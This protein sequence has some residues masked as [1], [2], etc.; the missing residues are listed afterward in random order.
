MTVSY[1][2]EI[3]LK[4]YP[5]VT[6]ADLRRLKTKL[7][8]E[9]YNYYCAGGVL[10]ICGELDEEDVTAEEVASHLRWILSWFA[11]IDA[12]V[13]AQAQYADDDYVASTHAGMNHYAANSNWY[14]W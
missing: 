6:K 11:D 8:I 2:C 10:I 1:N 14:T 9:D 4:E 7:A 12:D 5:H 3:D 13:T